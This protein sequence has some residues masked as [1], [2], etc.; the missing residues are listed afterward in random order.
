MDG[1]VCSGNGCDIEGMFGV[2]DFDDTMIKMF[3]NV[4]LIM[5]NV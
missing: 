1:V 5:Q 4:K 2:V 3:I